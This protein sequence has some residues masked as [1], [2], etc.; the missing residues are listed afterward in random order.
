VWSARARGPA[1]SG[2]AASR[3]NSSS[4]AA[5]PR[6]SAKAA[7]GGIQREGSRGTPGTRHRRPAGD[8]ILRSPQPDAGYWRHEF[9][10]ARLNHSQW[11]LNLHVARYPSPGIPFY[12]SKVAGYEVD[13]KMTEG[14]PQTVRL[15]HFGAPHGGTPGSPVSPLLATG[16]LRSLVSGPVAGAVIQVGV[17]GPRR[18][19]PGSGGDALHSPR[20]F[21]DGCARNGVPSSGVLTS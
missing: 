16:C 13:T 5:K 1:S 6:D 20:A 19:K 17:A 2:A 3:S 4:D 7:G 18:A 10:E 9:A 12:S 21:L 15:S 14:W 11:A 8:P